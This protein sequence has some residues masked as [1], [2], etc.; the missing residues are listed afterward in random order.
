VNILG[1][2]TDDPE[3]ERGPDVLAR[4]EVPLAW[5][6]EGATLEIAL[7]R[8]LV[9]GRCEG[10]GCDAC[11]RKGAFDQGALAAGAEVVVSLPRAAGETA[12]PVRLR[13]PG[14]GASSAAEGVPPGHLLLT[15][16]PREDE[17]WVPSAQVRR[18]VAPEAPPRAPRGLVGIWAAFIG[19]ITLLAWWLF[20]R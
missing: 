9:C 17:G 3:A 10:G 4:V 13:V 7:P 19:L 16:V 20:R 6:A 5:V 1:R 14:H 11:G 8:L 2:V 12:L 15:V 18:L